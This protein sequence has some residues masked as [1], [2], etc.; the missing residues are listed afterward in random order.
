MFG[1]Y[2]GFRCA[3]RSPDI[4]SLLVLQEGSSAMNVRAH[5]WERLNTF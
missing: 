5:R 1:A 2:A 4:P 3:A